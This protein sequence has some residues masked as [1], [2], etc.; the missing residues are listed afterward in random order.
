[1]TPFSPSSLYIAEP[2][3]KFGYEQHLR[4]P[5]EGL[6]L[7]G[8][9]ADRTKPAEMRV[10][11]IG[12]K[13]GIERYNRWVKQITSFIPAKKADQH[14]LAYP[15]FEAAFRTRWPL[16]ASVELTVS[17][18]EIAN[19]VR[20]S[21]R[22]KRVFDTVAIYEKAIRAHLRE[23]EAT[24]ALW[25]AIIPDEIH[26]YC[27]PKSSVPSAERIQLNSIMTRGAAKKLIAAP[28]LFEEDNAR[29]EPYRYEV[30]FHNQLKARLLD[31]QAVLQI[32]RE[33]T[34]APDEVEKETGRKRRMQD[35]A[36][37]AWN[38]TTTAYFKAGGK[39]WA[40]NSVRKG[41]CYIGLVFKRT[42][43][44]PNSKNACCGAQMF[45][46]SGDGLVFKGA[47]GPWYSATNKECHLP[48]AKAR[49]IVEMVVRAYKDRH[50]EE[51]SELFIHA[52][53]R[54][55]D[56]EWAGFS[57]AVGAETKLVGIR[58]QQT[59]E[60][61][62]FR[63]GRSPVLRGTAYQ[64]SERL[65][66]L[67]TLGF[68]PDLQTYPGREVPNPLMIEI[69]RGEAPMLDVLGDIL[70]LTKL[71]FNACI[72]GDG[73]PVTLRFASDVG[74]IL[75]AAPLGDLPPLPFKHYI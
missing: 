8:P 17:K 51:P 40:L 62:L 56:D 71:N 22:H 14:H 45:L 37:I 23:E 4:D 42:E 28:S 69:T 9:L 5:K 48:K 61:K 72:Y 55:S 24:P 50:G 10:G 31:R 33:S 60:L 52:R 66:Y 41:V 38:L 35:P 68:I 74:E 63:T 27:R 32:V 34:I 21:D 54:F 36:S 73:V 47:V 3:L 53:H 46:N 59:Q 67:W 70:G 16:L 30:D 43:T 44:D 65:S 20:L 26:R 19:S 25:F 49:E 7:F 39:P 6:F 13:A 58:I 2:D 11:V 57:E 12:T 18:D 1:M 75:T 29:A 15:G 64:V